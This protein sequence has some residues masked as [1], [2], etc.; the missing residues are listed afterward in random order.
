MGCSA[1]SIR[2][3]CHNFE[4]DTKIESRK[5]QA[6]PALRSK[7]KLYRRFLM[8]K[9]FYSAPA[10]VVVCEGK[11]DNIYLLHAIRSLAVSYPKLGAISPNN[12]IT[13]N[14]RILK[15]VKTSVGR[16]LQLGE[17]T[18]FLEAFIKGYCE[19]IN[20]FKAVGM[21]CAVVLVVDNDSGTDGIC[22]VIRQLTTKSPSRTDPFTHIAGNLYM[23]FTPLKAGATKSA[24]EDCFVDAIKNLNLGGKTFNPDSKADSSRY[25]SKHILSQHVRENAAK[26]DFTGFTGLLDRIT[27]AIQTH[28]SKQAVVAA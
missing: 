23:V 17:G 8:F 28:Q 24:I 14:I 19:E 6:K 22:N 21:R 3:D 27:A 12:K 7:Q 9:D 15:T 26:I 4:I 13:L 1:T 2:V 5:H 11:T 20:K 25:F 16:V 10:P 18:S